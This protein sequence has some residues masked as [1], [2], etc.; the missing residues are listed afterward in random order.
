VVRALLAGADPNLP[1]DDRAGPLTLERATGLEPATA[2]L[3]NRIGP[4]TSDGNGSLV[5]ANCAV[6]PSGSVQP[7]PTEASNS[8]LF[9]T[10]LLRGPLLTVRDAA[11]RLGVCAATVYKL[12]AEGS[13]THVR[14]LNAI[15]IAPKDLAAFVHARRLGGVPLH[16]HD[17]GEKPRG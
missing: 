15:R 5:E 8:Q 9:A 6:A 13:L 7:F 12:C 2:C 11:E 10:N 17:L 4:V 1:G 14:V 16:D 3:G